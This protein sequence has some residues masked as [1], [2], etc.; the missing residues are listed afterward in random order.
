MLLYTVDMRKTKHSQ[1]PVACFHSS[2]VHFHVQLS[3]N[4]YRVDHPTNCQ[5][6]YRSITEKSKG[7]CL[8][9]RAAATSWR[10]SVIQYENSPM[11]LFISMERSVGGQLG[12]RPAHSSVVWATNCTGRKTLCNCRAI[13][14]GGGVTMATGLRD[15]AEEPVLAG[16]RKSAGR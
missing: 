16:G 14:Y 4:R 11:R 3:V 7:Q 1:R 15:R 2:F 10:F 5:H 12:V 6:L 13:V 8:C 9:S